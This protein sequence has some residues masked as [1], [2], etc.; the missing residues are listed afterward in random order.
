MNGWVWAGTAITIERT[1]QG[2]Q[3]PAQS[4]QEKE[5]T[6]AMLRGVLERRYNFDTKFLDLSNLVQDEGLQSKNVFDQ[7]STTSKIF[8]ALMRILELAFDTPE[9]KHAAVTSVSLADNDLGD[10]SYVTTL[11]ITLPKLLNLDLSNNKIEKLTALEPWRKRFYHLQ[12]LILSGNPIEQ[13]EP[14]LPAEIM[15]WYPNL[16]M[17]NNVQVRTEEEVAKKSATVTE[18]PFPI[19]SPRFQ[20]E[21]G[22]AENFIRTFFTGFDNDRTALAVHYYDDNSSFSYSV[23]TQAPRDPAASEATEKQEWD[24]YIRNSRN[25]KKISQLP[26][27]QSRIFRGSKAVG[28]AFAAMPWTKHP[29]LATEAKK[30]MIEAHIQPGVPDP[31]SQNP[32][33]VDGFMIT[34]HGEFD[35]VDSKKRRSFDRTFII[36]PGG[37]GK[38]I[39]SMI[40]HNI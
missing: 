25:L 36:G 39:P 5:D 2:D 34:I 35:E 18:L 27:R 17:L 26:A 4:S 33:G 12:H 14:E 10:I 30:W 32:G 21:G 1:G 13:N 38:R 19:R 8:P 20:D 28:D 37:P 29:D 22:I 31:A 11:S 9:E 6:K 40:T 23:N 24:H 3:G 16:R 15:K 7:K